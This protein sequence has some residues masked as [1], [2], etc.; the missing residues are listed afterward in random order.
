MYRS[1]RLLIALRFQ[2]FCFSGK[3]EP[4]STM[5][6]LFVPFR[7]ISIRLLVSFRVFTQAEI[8]APGRVT[9]FLFQLPETKC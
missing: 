9:A 5:E 6:F 4:G 7:T 8:Y 3:R 2:R 1:H